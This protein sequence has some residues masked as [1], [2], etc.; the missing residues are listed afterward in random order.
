MF[1]YIPAQPVTV[2]DKGSSI[3][4]AIGIIV[5]M[6]CVD[7]PFVIVRLWTMIDFGLIVSDIIHPLKNIAMICF[8]C[9]QLYII[10]DT[11][12]KLRQVRKSQMDLSLTRKTFQSGIWDLGKGHLTITDVQTQ[13]EDGDDTTSVESVAGSTNPNFEEQEEDT[14]KPKKRIGSKSKV[15]KVDDM[16][17]ADVEET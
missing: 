11:R 12:K 16:E 14:T 6:A 15:N 5:S 17:L 10:Y 2:L 4:A 3:G 9:T 1:R 13:A 8:G 7:F